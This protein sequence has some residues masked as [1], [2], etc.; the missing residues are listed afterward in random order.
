MLH[1]AI[2]VAACRN[3]KKFFFKSYVVPLGG[4]Q[5][6]NIYFY[7]KQRQTKGK[8]SFTQNFTTFFLFTLSN[9][10]SFYFFEIRINK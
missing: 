2:I 1:A 3:V 7:V 5:L 4:F 6:F 9:K 8:Q 10:A